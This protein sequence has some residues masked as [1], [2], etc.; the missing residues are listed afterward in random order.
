MQS[1]FRIPLQKQYDNHNNRSVDPDPLTVNQI[2]FI[3]YNSN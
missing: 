1:I 3:V 2:Y